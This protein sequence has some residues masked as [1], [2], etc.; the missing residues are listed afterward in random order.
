[1][2]IFLLARALKSLTVE[3]LVD[4]EQ[5]FLLPDNDMLWSAGSFS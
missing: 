3:T 4:L 5:Q 1:M 2:N